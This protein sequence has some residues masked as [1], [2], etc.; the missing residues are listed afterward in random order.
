MNGKRPY[1]WRAVNDEGGILEIL[2][3][4]HR[5]KRAALKLLRKLLKKHGSVPDTVVTD[6]LPS[7]GAAVR[8][9]NLSN[10]HGLGGKKN[11]RAGA[12]R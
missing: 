7:Y 2:V 11:N 4:S 1:L 3:Q 8:E 12:D 5:N 6:K 9:L 10:F